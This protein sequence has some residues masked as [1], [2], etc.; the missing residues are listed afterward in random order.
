MTSIEAQ[1][2]GLTKN[3][4]D[5]L[6][7]ITKLKAIDTNSFVT[8]TTFSADTNAL[9]DKIG[10]V[11]KKPP[12]ISG[13][14]TKT[15]LND[16]LQTSTFNSKVTEV[17]NKI[18]DADI[19]AK[20]ANTK[21][22]TIR[23]DSTDYAKKTDVAH[24]IT[25]IKNDYVTNAS[26]T[27]QLND[28]K[29]QHIAT[30]VTIIDNKTK[31][32]ASDILALEN[33][34]KQREDIINENKTGLSVN[35]GFF[36]YLQQ[37]Y[38]VYECKI[39]SFNF[40][41]AKISEWKLTSIFNYSNDSNMRGIEDPKTKL[42][43]LKN[44]GRMHVSLFGNHFKQNE[45]IIPNNNNVINIYCVYELRKVNIPLIIEFAILNALFGA[46]EIT[47][48]ANTSK[49]KYKRYG[50][51]F[52]KG[53]SFSEGSINNGRNVLIFGVHESS[54]LHSNNKANNI[55]V[56]GKGPVQGIDDTTLYAEN[57]Y[58]QNFTQPNR[59][60]VLSLHYNDDNSY[61]FVNGKQELKFKCKKIN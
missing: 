55:Y 39:H 24:D 42:P 16:Y 26:L 35:R 34:L 36:H 23:S 57:V 56:M 4:V 30:E 48:S 31:K 61:L 43:E 13:L 10:G 41:N 2:A 1:I 7:D 27:S 33:K 52:L 47:K 18:K 3:T 15:S 21:A 29:G 54:L 14:A 37:S 25:T 60:F 59:K 28:L 32:N 17:E 46:M 22:N 50:I 19:I 44:D 45:V 8:R 53:G 9:N 12:D 11:E 6:A 38:L 49:Y 5:N 51:C 40:N 58:S 20:N